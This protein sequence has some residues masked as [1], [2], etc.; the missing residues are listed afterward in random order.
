MTFLPYS[1]VESHVTGREGFPVALLLGEGSGYQTFLFPGHRWP[2][3][4]PVGLK[5]NQSS[6]ESPRVPVD[7][8]WRP[9]WGRTREHIYESSDCLAS[10]GLA[11]WVWSGETRQKPQ[12]APRT[13]RLGPRSREKAS[14][15]YQLF[16]LFCYLTL[17]KYFYLEILEN[18]NKKPKIPR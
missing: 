7:S 4:Y 10:A 12:R 13:P 15:T 1:A 16:I 11:P 18:R 17:L 9:L 2:A 5:R 8:H 14:F 6:P 3:A